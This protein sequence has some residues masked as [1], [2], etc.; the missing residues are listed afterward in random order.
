MH[1]FRLVTAYCESRPTT[2]NWTLE[3]A[4]RIWICFRVQYHIFFIQATCSVPSACSA[5]CVLWKKFMGKRAGILDTMKRDVQ[6]NVSGELHTTDCYCLQ[7][8]NLSS[9]KV[10]KFPLNKTTS[11][12]F[13]SS[14]FFFYFYHDQQMHNYISVF[15]L[16]ALN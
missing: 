8:R 11:I 14:L 10:H 13:F 7:E 2:V 12:N 1:K 6:R 9:V 5:I 4:W 16:I 3:N 15:Q